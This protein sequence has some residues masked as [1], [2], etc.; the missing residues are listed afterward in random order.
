MKGNKKC[1]LS[2]SQPPTVQ[3]VISEQPDFKTH[4]CVADQVMTAPF[5]ATYLYFLFAK[6]EPGKTHPSSVVSS[7]P[8]NISIVGL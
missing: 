1:L 8:S 6:Q 2:F 3:L 5:E 7:L 4:P